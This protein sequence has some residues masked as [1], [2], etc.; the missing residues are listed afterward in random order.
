MKI[1]TRVIAAEKAL[2][3]TVKVFGEGKYIGDQVPD[4]PG[5]REM[6]LT[7]PYIK[8]DDGTTIWGFQCW[9]GE[10]DQAKAEWEKRGLEIVKVEN[11]NEILPYR[12]E[13]DE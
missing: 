2:V 6:G 13:K 10:V 7:C 4:V 1:G 8:L 9:W 3:T 11:T 5:F 12:K